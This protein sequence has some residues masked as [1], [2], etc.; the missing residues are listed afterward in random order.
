M[1]H[2]GHFNGFLL[3]LGVLAFQLGKVL[4]GIHGSIAVA[5]YLVAG[6]GAARCAGCA[7]CGRGGG[8]PQACNVLLLLAD[9][10]PHFRQ[11]FKP[12]PQLLHIAS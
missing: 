12:R 8:I 6:A 11:A 7:G 9:P 2:V 10:C 4:L 5:A 3:H 1:E